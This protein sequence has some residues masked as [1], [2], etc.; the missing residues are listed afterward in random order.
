MIVTGVCHD[1]T[2]FKLQPPAIHL[3]NP[4]VQEIYP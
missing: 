1:G 3:F 2:A 4:E